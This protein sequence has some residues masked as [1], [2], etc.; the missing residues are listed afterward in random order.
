MA[1]FHLEILTPAKKIYSAEVAKVIVPAYDGEVGVLP[2]HNDFVG[3]LGT[4]V[5]RADTEEH[6]THICM[7]CSGIYQIKGGTLTIFADLA[8]DAGEI[9]PELER[10]ALGHL[11]IKMK[12]EELT[13]AQLDELMLQELRINSKLA[14]LDYQAKH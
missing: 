13:P 7:I 11:H 10:D 14:A 5:L 1:N 8:V 9:D 6:H 4:G 12:K 2:G 3:V